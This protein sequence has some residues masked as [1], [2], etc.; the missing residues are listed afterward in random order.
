MI[1]PPNAA[2]KLGFSEIREILKLHCLSVMGQ[3]MVDKMG[4]LTQFDQIN[5]FLR[6]TKEFKEILESDAPL[7]ISHFFDVKSL[8]EKIRIEGAF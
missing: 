3:Q 7:H 4:M 6:Q 2:D 8:A 1:Y 5:K